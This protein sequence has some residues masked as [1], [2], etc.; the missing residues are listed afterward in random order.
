MYKQYIKQAIQML[1]E[2]TLVSVISIAGTALAIAVILVM[3]LVFQINSAGYAPESNRNRLLYVGRTEVMPKSGG[4]SRNRGAMSS[5][6]VKECFYTLRKPEAVAGIYK[7]ERALSLPDK[8]LFKKYRLAYTDPAYWKIYDHP[9]LEGKPF[10]EADFR[11][12]IPKA[13]L[14]S[15]VA[16]DLFGT[17]QAIG[18][19]VVINFVTFTVCGVVKDVPSPLMSAYSEVWIPYTCNDELMALNPNYGE[20]MVGNFSVVMLA[21]SSSDF[22]ALR[23][24]LDQQRKR[25]N[26]GKSDY[27]VAFG[28]GPLSQLDMAMGSNTWEKVDWKDYLADTGSFLLFL[29]LVPA[30]NL[31][32][33]IQSSVQKRKEEIGL[34]K[35]FGATRRNVLSQVLSENL[36]QT[37]IGGVIGI[38]LS[39]LLLAVGKSFMLDEGVRLTAAM[40]FKPGLFIAAILLT[41]LLN[42]LSS[43]IPAWRT[44]RQPI[45]ESLKG[46]E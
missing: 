17:G 42:L 9:F 24:E 28:P 22:D 23:T 35:A 12:A 14:S 15:R 32:G 8:Q 16:T 30:L 44:M 1:R 36:V 34:R 5:E 40:L 29:L 7:D 10:D 13:V 11:S 27:E 26:E 25:Y 33:V 31:T 4:G 20:N 46:N 18:R 39:M 19:Q 6:V 41:F 38:A 2:N 37:M 21:R 45:V 3:V 43:I